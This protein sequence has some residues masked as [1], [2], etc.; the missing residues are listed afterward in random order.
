MQS[1]LNSLKH[2]FNQQPYASLAQRKAW[3]TALEKGIRQYSEVLCNAVSQDFGYRSSDETRL[4]EIMPTLSGIKYHLNQLKGWLKPQ[5]R[6]VH[7]SFL[8]ASNK[9]LPQPLGVVGIIVPWNYPIF[10]ATGPLTAA[11]AA[12]NKVMLKLS[13]FTPATNAVFVQMLQQ[14]LPDQVKVIEGDAQVAADFSALAFDHLLFT[15]ST[16]VGKKVMQAASANL[17]PVTLELGGKSPTLIAP[18]A[19][20]SSAISRI[21]FGKAANAGQ[22]CVAPDYVLLPRAKQ[23]EF[24]DKAK[25]CFAAFYPAGVQGS[26]YSA[27]VNERQFSRLQHYLTEAAALKADIIALDGK[28][29]QQSTDRKLAI[30]LVLDAPDQALL[31]QDEIFGPILPVKLYD[32]LDEAITFINQQPR[33]LALYLF[34]DNT[35]SQQ[36]VM[37]QTH[38]G[39]VC[40]NDTLVHVG[41]DDLPFGGVG[42]S[43]MG[44]YHGDAGFRTFS[45]Y[46]PIHKKG[47]INSGQFIYPPYNRTLFRWILSWLLR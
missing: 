28:D 31:W 13:E 33:P 18:D 29:W 26:D 47:R 19:D 11:L 23:T 20:I 37:Q 14:Y 10:L 24:I 41:Q 39:G 8:P 7:Y 2:E 1:I 21:L 9:L 15:G 22:T 32:T 5:R 25:Q 46:K 40:I 44:A 42:P 43:G 36:Q 27:I 17:T 45:H 16:N 34:S 6:H 4:L 3:L 30:Q 38:A 35:D 12:G